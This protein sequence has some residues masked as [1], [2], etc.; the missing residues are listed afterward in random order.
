MFCFV[1]VNP[2]M[3]KINLVK[4]QNLPKKIIRIKGEHA[5]KQT[6]IDVFLRGLYK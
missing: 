2:I 1:K 4:M 3:A 5:L 6:S